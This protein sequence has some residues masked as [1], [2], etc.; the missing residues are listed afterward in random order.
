MAPH[1]NKGKSEVSF[2]LHKMSEREYN[3]LERTIL[4][5][6]QKKGTITLLLNII[7][8]KKIIIFIFFYILLI[9]YNNNT[10]S[11]RKKPKRKYYKKKQSTRALANKALSLAKMGQNPLKHHGVNST[12]TVTTT[13]VITRLSSVA[14]GTTEATREGDETRLVSSRL[15]YLFSKDASSDITVI[16]IILFRDMR[17]VDEP[18]LQ[19]TTNSV[20]S[21][22]GYTYSQVKQDNK[23]RFIILKD[24]SIVLDSAQAIGKI[25]EIYL[26]LRNVKA[27]YKGDGA[28]LA[29]IKKGH[30]YVLMVSNE[31]TNSP[32][33]R[34][35]NRLY[36]R[37]V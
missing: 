2:F 8:K 17:G 18:N 3:S 32:V 24:T 14:V 10:M 30:L 35:T 19:G 7:A 5:L 22:G 28:D 36:F 9:Y 20:L 26:N 13:G 37:S 4:M 1:Q 12:T 33:V 15:R 16:R 34:W 31:A 11:Y 6:K 25:G 27:T 23:T 21:T 29:D